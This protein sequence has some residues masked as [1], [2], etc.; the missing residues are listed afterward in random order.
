MKGYRF[1]L[2]Y[3]SP[4]KKRKGQDQGNVLAF[5]V[6]SPWW[7]EDDNYAHGCVAAV[8]FVPDSPVCFTTCYES[9]LHRNCK[10][11]SEKQARVIHPALFAYLDAP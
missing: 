8:S 2:E 5:D 1:Y 3:D 9:Y 4:A 7:I 11:I 10:R 6:D